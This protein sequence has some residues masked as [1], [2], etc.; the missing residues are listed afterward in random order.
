ML[1]FWNTKEK[2][3]RRKKFINFN[4]IDGTEYQR[5][6]SDYKGCAIDDPDGIYPYKNKPGHAVLFDGIGNVEVD[7]E[8]AI[9]IRDFFIFLDSDK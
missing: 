2:Q 9:K 6:V 1:K 5:A 8:T 3:L 4:G 7:R